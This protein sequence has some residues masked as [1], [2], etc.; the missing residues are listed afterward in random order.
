MDFSLEKSHIRH[1]FFP[2]EVHV[3][4][5]KYLLLSTSEQ[6]QI[7]AT[8]KTWY[9]DGTFKL[10]RHPC[11][12]LF[13]ITAF[14]KHAD[15]AKQVTLIRCS[16]LCVEERKLITRRYFIIINYYLLKHMLY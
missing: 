4:E 14:V 6:L 12:Q 9:I 5:H 16:S 3:K 13:S 10:C 15:H 7:L 11:V 8:V 2:G 1:D